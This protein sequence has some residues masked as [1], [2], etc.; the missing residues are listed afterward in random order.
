MKGADT[1]KFL[2]SLVV[3]WIHT[4]NSDLWG[5]TKWAVPVFFVLS[6]FFLWTKIIAETEAD[7]KC[8]AVQR[9]L[10]NNLRLYLVWT[11]IFLPFAI[12]GFASEGMPFLK[13]CAVWVRNVVLVGENYLSWPLWYLLGLL[14]AGAMIW[15]SLKVKVP[16]WSLCILAVILF[17]VPRLIDLE[18]I[19][20]YVTLFKHTSNGLFV[21]FPFMMLGGFIRKVFPDITGWPKPSRWYRPSLCLRFFSVHIYLTHMLFAGALMLTCSPAKGLLLWGVTVLLTL[22]SGVV[23]WL[24]PSAQKALYGRVYAVR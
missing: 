22:V 7:G 6:G 24:I 12:Y 4:G 14:W 16:F 9:W 5:V 2:L 17:A 11:L 13:A 15:L 1:L 19:H 10:G 23:L 3:V 8:K 18:G 21:G 20:G